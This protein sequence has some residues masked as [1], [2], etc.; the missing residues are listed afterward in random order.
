MRAAVELLVVGGGV[1]DLLDLM[2]PH[3]ATVLKER[4]L[5]GFQPAEIRVA[6]L[7]EAA[8]LVGAAAVGRDAARDT[9]SA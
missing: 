2:Q 5:V 8:G 3:V 7:G 4:L 1:S 6:A 9:G